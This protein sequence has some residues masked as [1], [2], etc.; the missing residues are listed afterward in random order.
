MGLDNTPTYSAFISTAGQ[1]DSPAGIMTNLGLINE[2]I[3]ILKKGAV[4][5]Y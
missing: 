2:K 1:I 5:M 4:S 3:L